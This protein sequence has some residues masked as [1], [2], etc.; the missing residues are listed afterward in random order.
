M[1][2]A[3]ADMEPHFSDER[4]LPQS[5]GDV[6]QDLRRPSADG[7][8]VRRRRRAPRQR[9]LDDA[10]VRLGGFGGVVGQASLHRKGV[11]LQPV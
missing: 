6:A 5:L 9:R 4:A 11:A 2:K 7:G 1:K 8:V 10:L 3:L